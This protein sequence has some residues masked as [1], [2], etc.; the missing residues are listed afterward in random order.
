MLWRN[1]CISL[2]IG[3]YVSMHSNGQSRVNRCLSIISV[4]GSDPNANASHA[5]E[6]QFNAKA[7]KSSFNLSQC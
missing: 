1:G 2:F 6:E 5:V 4:Y 7:L 3:M